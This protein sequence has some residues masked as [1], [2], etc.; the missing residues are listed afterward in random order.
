M[1]Q[2]IIT[3]GKNHT[4]WRKGVG[5]VQGE[6]MWV[7]ERIC[8]KNR[9]FYPLPPNFNHFKREI[10]F[11]NW[12]T[13]KEE[14]VFIAGRLTDGLGAD[15]ALYK[16]ELT[17]AERVDTGL[18]EADAD[19]VAVCRLVEDAQVQLGVHSQACITFMQDL[20]KRATSLT[21]IL[22]RLISR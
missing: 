15:F 11:Y 18:G 7:L 21:C 6:E 12:V 8:E 14:S 19:L 5:R 2:N 13:N 10:A 20:I 9:P 1:K 17:S 3:Y 4:N 22:I 16:G